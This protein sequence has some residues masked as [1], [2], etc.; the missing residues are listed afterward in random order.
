MKNKTMEN[1][2]YITF[3]IYSSKLMSQ[4]F[5]FNVGG[6]VYKAIICFQYTSGV[7][8]HYKQVQPSIW[9]WSEIRRGLLSSRN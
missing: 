8:H 2:E 1:V 6:L 5:S 3:N 7:K 4:F 9:L